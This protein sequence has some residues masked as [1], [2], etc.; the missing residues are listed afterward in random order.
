[1][2][3]DPPLGRVG[4]VNFRKM[5]KMLMPGFFKYVAWYG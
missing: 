4:C 2:V 3:N 1:M 5:W